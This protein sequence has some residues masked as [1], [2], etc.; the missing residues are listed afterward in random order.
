MADKPPIR[1]GASTPAAKPSFARW[2]K[3]FLAELAATSNVSAAARKAAVSTASAYD[4]RRSNAAFNRAWQQ[5]LCEGYDHLE[6]ELLHRLR[7]GEVKPA[8]GAKRGTRAFDNATAFRLLS[9]H[10]ESA[11]RF[12]AVRNNEDAEAIIQSI[13]AKLE[14]MRQRRLALAAPSEAGKA[15]PDGGS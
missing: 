11:A 3:T 5:A 10:R 4:A 12:R 6:M 9:A 2:S 14:A 1:R 13:N 8:T 15:V 7:N